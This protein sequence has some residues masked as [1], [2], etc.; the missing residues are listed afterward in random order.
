VNSILRG[1]RLALLAGCVTAFSGCDMKPSVAAPSPQSTAAPTP[2]PLPNLTGDY[3]ITFVAGNCD[4]GVPGAMLPAE[5]LTR[6]YASHLEQSG[7]DVK[8]MLKSPPEVFGLQ[9]PKLWGQIQP[10]NTLAL[11]NY[12]GNDQ[13]ESISEQV[14]PAN[15]LSIYVSEMNLAGSPEGLSGQFGGSVLIYALKGGAWNEISSGCFSSGH[16]VTFARTLLN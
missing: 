14:T 7:K 8:I 13:W 12:Y 10:N 11:T 5:F 9:Y 6:T 15:L 16:F 3:T 2:P 1:A 4:G